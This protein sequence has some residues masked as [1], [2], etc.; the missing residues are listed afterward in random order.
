M[1]N[2]NYFIGLDIGTDSVGYAVTDTAAQYNLL[3]SC[4]EPMWGVTLFDKGNL[5]DNRRA[6]RVERRRID[7]RQ[8]RIL[9]LQELF[10]PAVSEV[11]VNFYKRIKESALV[12]TDS[13]EPYCLF[14]DKNYTDA[15]YH[16]QYPTIHHLIAEL[17][18]DSTA[19]DVRLVYIACAWLLAHRGHFLS[20]ISTDNVNELRDFGS[21]YY[22]LMNFLQEYSQE[23]DYR[24][25]WVLDENGV[26]EFGEILKQ[27]GVNRKIVRLQTLLNDGKKFKK[28]AGDETAFPFSIEGIIRLLCGGT[29][30][31][32]DLY[33]NPAYS[34]FG[35]VCL[36]ADDESM[37]N[38]IAALGD[39]GELIIRLKAIFDWAIL[40]DLLNNCSYISQAKVNIYEQH[41]ADLRYLKEF[42]RKNYPAETYNQ[43]FRKFVK[44]NYVAYCGNI[45]NCPNTDKYEKC[46]SREDLCKYL[47]NELELDNGA[48]ENAV[49]PEIL[50]R[51]RNNDFLP[52][53]VSTE[54]RVIPYQVYYVE[55]KK[56][57]E[58][59]SGYLPFLKEED[60]DGYVTREKILSIMRF[61]IPYYVGPLNKNNNEHAWIVR[62]E[63]ESGRILP[64]NFEEKVDL[65]ASNEEFIK[66][67]TNTCSYLAG[68]E[69]LPKSSL[70]YSRFE[71]LNEINNLKIN[72]VSIDIKK[73][74]MIFCELFM[75]K[76]K[77]TPKAV[78]EYLIRNNMCSKQDAE[79]LSGID[80]D[81]KSSLSS[82]IAFERLLA[83]GA[84]T[85]ADAEK[86]IKAKTYTEDKNR[87]NKW[88]GE[89]FG[90]LTA[91]DRK[92]IG[93]LKFKDFGRLSKTLLSGI[94][95]RK[96]DSETSEIG[97]AENTV[98][99]FM[100]ESNATLSELL[101]S[102]KYT[103]AQTIQQMND[104]YYSK[105][106]KTLDDRMKD[107][108]ISNAVKRPIIRTFDVVN[109]I[110]KVMGGAPKKIF[111]EMARGGDKEKKNKRTVS[112]KQ[113]LLDLYKSIRDTD[114]REIAGELEI[115]LEK[116]EEN[117]LQSKRLFLYYTQLGRCMYSGEPIDIR[118]LMNGNKE[119]NIDHIYPQAKVTDDSIIN[120]KV[121]VLSKINGEKKDVY[122]INREIQ[123]KMHGFWSKLKANG[124]IGEEKYNRL[125]RTK[126]FSQEEEWGFIN[127]QLVETRQSTKAVATLLAEKYPDTQIV[128]V[129]AGMVSDFRQ[130]YKLP[131]SR[132]LNDLHHAKDAY[133]NVV[134]GNVYNEHFTKQWFLKNRNNYTVNMKKLLE[135]PVYGG[136]VRVWDGAP[137][138]AAVKRTML[139]NNCHM[140]FYS[141]M[142]KHGNKGGFFDQNPLRAGKGSFPRKA[143]LPVEKYGGYNRLTTAFSVLVHY[144]LGKKPVAEFVPVALINAER[145]LAD[146]DYALNGYIRQHLD[147]KAADI[148][149]LLGGRPV[150]IG[151]EFALD[152]LH[153]LF[154]GQGTA[155]TH[156]GMKVFTPLVLPEQDVQYVKAVESFVQKTEENE[157]LEYSENETVSKDGNIALYDLL[158]E[159]YSSRPYSLRPENQCIKLTK[160]RDTKVRGT[161]ERDI[162]GRDKFIALGVKEQCVVLLHVLSQ[163]NR[164]AI[165]DPT[166]KLTGNCRLPS[167]L[168]GWKYGD[169]RIIDRSAS[170]L[171]KKTSDNLLELI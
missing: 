29:Y 18:S 21:S 57:L 156:I 134:C 132:A 55:L 159:K 17:I 116:E 136:G 3:K 98:I 161:E 11:D 83:S 43:I 79:T 33:S 88:L 34:D 46:L 7:R 131:K 151:T 118:A 138:V 76:K 69:V 77:V 130:E 15:D 154:G 52:K 82:R 39:D 90:S 143:D 54:N 111:V 47:R 51:I 19:H 129:K 40:D 66:R 139:K 71:V 105:Y 38:V 86:I 127:R 102:D 128:Y 117:R 133:L 70:L 80:I 35:S 119:Y 99:G 1:K 168:N 171:R 93:N 74:Q 157:K 95:G 96:I 12:R 6:H 91:D 153:V 58:N 125:T 65:D 155:D 152:G 63:G 28:K 124:L 13:E 72:G 135:G 30:P 61:R 163:F 109:D 146:F 104:E 41:R 4:G 169:V 23:S 94:T 49:D 97:S 158:I 141:V 101:L 14:N 37:E 165:A 144:Q 16:R 160:G 2:K 126:G 87:F 62:R 121:L 140:T 64:W 167:I 31:L 120:N 148:K 115:S 42:V 142:R 107:M 45:K 44:N 10:A 27:K 162:K 145:F 36:S 25:P 89:N 24:A 26:K 32:A 166:L 68:E 59:A 92:Y 84:L 48:G 5:C 112:R 53:Q 122:P 81:I 106:P 60:A 149:L 8:Q 73:K 75:K 9:L 164:T 100:W 67:M 110:V 113:Q 50:N 114:L 78:K 20:D 147:P 108:Y 137:S 103:F 123:S 56:I 22:G 150:K 85:E 170:G